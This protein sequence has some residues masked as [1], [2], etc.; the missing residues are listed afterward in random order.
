MK[1]LDCTLRDGGYYNDWDFDSRTVDCYLAAMNRLPVDMI[2]VGYRSL[3][4]K[5]YMGRFGYSPRF[6]LERVRERSQKQVAVMFNEKDIRVSDLPTVLDPVADLVDMVRMAVA[7]TN[8]ARAIE[9]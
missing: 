3:P 4:S 7:P 5:S 8:M 2:E 9:L 1:I 6:E